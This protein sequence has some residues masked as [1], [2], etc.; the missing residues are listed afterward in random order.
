MRLATHVRGPVPVE[1]AW[2]RYADP[3]LW[4]SWAP[5]I[6]GVDLD[7]HPPIHA[8]LSGTVRALL[9][10]RVRFEVTEVDEAARRWSW[11]VH[12]PLVTLRLDHT[13]EPTSTGTRAGLVV[14]GPAPVVLPYVPLARL[15]LHRLL[16][17]D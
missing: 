16:A 8:G 4:S 5:Q 11:T 13:L 14:P 6:T 9:G 17:T 10:L 2:A 1:I 15:A 3:R 7:G 12:P